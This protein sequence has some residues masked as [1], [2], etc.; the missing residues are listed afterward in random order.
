MT[1]DDDIFALEYY[2]LTFAS[3][4]KLLRRLIEPSKPSSRSDA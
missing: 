1:K 2:K 3:N 4:E